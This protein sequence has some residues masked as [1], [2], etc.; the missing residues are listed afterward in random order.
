MPSGRQPQRRSDRPRIAGQRGR[1]N[2]AGGGGRSSF[3]TFGPEAPCR[4]AAGAGKSQRFGLSPPREG[5]SMSE[6]DRPDLGIRD[7]GLKENEF[8]KIYGRAIRSRY[9]VVEAAGRPP[10]NETADVGASRGLTGKCVYLAGPLD[11]PDSKKF[12]HIVDEVVHQLTISSG[13]SVYVPGRAWVINPEFAGYPSSRV[14]QKSNHDALRRV[15]I[16]LVLVPQIP[17][18]GTWRDVQ[19]AVSLGLPV[20]AWDLR[21]SGQPHVAFSDLFV[22]AGPNVNEFLDYVD[23]R[24]QD[25]GV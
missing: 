20:F 3:G 17:A 16:C 2:R 22:F 24:L 11:D 4:V 25:G 6:T 18:Y 21:N 7:I 12:T 10:T 19:V 5:G 13:C 1:Q 23:R 9:G 15:N 14:V 8:D